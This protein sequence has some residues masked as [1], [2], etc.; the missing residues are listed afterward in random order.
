MS[1]KR[2]WQIE[3]VTVTAAFF[4]LST[5]CGVYDFDRPQSILLERYPSLVPAARLR[6][7]DS[8]RV[9]DSEK[10]Q[11]CLSPRLT[12]ARRG[13]RR[14]PTPQRRRERAPR[15]DGLS[16]AWMRLD[17]AVAVGA[18]GQPHRR[19]AASRGPQRGGGR[20]AGGARRG[21][22]RRR[23]LYSGKAF[24]DS[25]DLKY[26]RLTRRG[27]RRRRRG[28]TPPRRRR[29]QAAKPCVCVCACVCVCVCVSEYVCVCVC[30][31]VCV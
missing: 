23:G 9:G 3:R 22:R 17:E 26:E 10:L 25:L 24:P 8:A 30:V 6:R 29:R 19:Q 2:P 31:C 15:L 28:P 18:R 1:N 21:R 4:G 5:V 12:A 27:R 13:R 7:G 11:K 16:P 14:G 20:G